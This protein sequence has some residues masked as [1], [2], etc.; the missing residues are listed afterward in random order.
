METNTLS[1][2]RFSSAMM[3]Q[4]KSE[5]MIELAGRA[6]PSMTRMRMNQSEKGKPLV[7]V[8]MDA[9]RLIVCEERR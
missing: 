4:M 8:S 6:T 2:A 9:G 7:Q 3:T 5:A 1:L